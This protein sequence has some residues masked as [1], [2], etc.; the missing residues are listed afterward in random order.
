MFYVKMMLFFS[1][2]T[3]IDE[4]EVKFPDNIL[5]F[6]YENISTMFSYYGIEGRLNIIRDSDGNK[7][8]VVFLTNNMDIS[9][10][11]AYYESLDMF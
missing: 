9:L 10:R 7:H 6:L 11:D 2:V 8:A 1:S 5:Y 3:L 4:H